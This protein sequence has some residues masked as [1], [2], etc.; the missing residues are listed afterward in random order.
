MR[1]LYLL[2]VRVLRR[3]FRATGIPVPGAA[4]RLDRAVKRSLTRP[5]GRD[6]TDELEA[7][8]RRVER[9]ETRTYLESIARRD[10]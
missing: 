2:M 3:F 5:A 4:R 9:L 6:H 8:N 1:S 10:E 7:L